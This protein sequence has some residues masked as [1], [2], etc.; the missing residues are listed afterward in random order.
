MKDILVK[1][2]MNTSVVSVKLQDSLKRVIRLLENNNFSGLLVVDEE[3]KI[4]GVISERDI[5]KYTRWIVGQPVRDPYKLIEEEGEAAHISGQRGLDVIEFVVSATAETVMTD[6]VI[7]AQEDS[8]ILD[9]VRLMNENDIN[10]V[11]IVDSWD[12]VKGIVTRGDILKT[13]EKMAGDA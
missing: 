10:R 9:V 11:P 3:G 2:I 1:N 5:L 8:S 6:K 7:K 13:F 4:K 12:N